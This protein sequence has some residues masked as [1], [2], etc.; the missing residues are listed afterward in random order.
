M[1]ER[2]AAGNFRI[3]GIEF[4]PTEKTIAWGKRMIA[5]WAESTVAAIRMDLK[6]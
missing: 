3:N 4:A 5:Y 6:E 2:I 1:K